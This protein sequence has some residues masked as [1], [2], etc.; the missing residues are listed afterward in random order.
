MIVWSYMVQYSPAL[1]SCMVPHGPIWPCIIFLHGRALN[2]S[3]LLS[4][5]VLYG[6]IWPCSIVLNGP[7]LLSCM[8]LYYCLIRS[9]FIVLSTRSYMTLYYCIEWSCIIVYCLVWSRII[10]LNGNVG[11]CIALHRADSPIG[12]CKVLFGAVLSSMYLF[13]L[14]SFSGYRIHYA[15]HVSIKSG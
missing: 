9:C 11:S 12:A 13:C 4:I 1:L 6:T 5:I 2:G 8:V 7:V 15:F 10:V 3:I 14:C